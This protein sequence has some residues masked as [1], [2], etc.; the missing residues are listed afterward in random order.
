MLSGSAQCAVA[1]RGVH[2]LAFPTTK[3]SVISENFANGDAVRVDYTDGPTLE[4]VKTMLSSYQLGHFDG[5]T[6][7]YE[8]SNTH[9]DQPQ[10]KYLST[11]R[12]MS[13]AAEMNI[14]AMLN[15]GNGPPDHECWCHDAS[16]DR[17]WER[18]A[19]VRRAFDVMDF[20]V[21]ET[22]VLQ[23]KEHTV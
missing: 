8:Y 16:G 1:I 20:S 9:S 10:T 22:P 12:H 21:A 15:I 13:E 14:V 18:D 5:M 3:F 17:Y 2:A 19:Q 7:C 6:D 23:P 11:T 4:S